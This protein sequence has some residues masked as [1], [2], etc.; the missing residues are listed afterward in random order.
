MLHQFF[1]SVI[2]GAGVGVHP[3]NIFQAVL[4]LSLCWFGGS[5]GG[6]VRAQ[7]IPESASVPAD[8]RA[9][10]PTPRF[11]DGVYLYGQSP[12]PE[13]LGQAYMVFEVRRENFVGA[14]YM[15]R[16]SFDCFTGRSRGNHLA[17]TIVDSYSQEP[18]AYSVNYDRASILA[19]RQGGADLQVGL[20]G[21]YPIEPVGENDRRILAVCKSDFDEI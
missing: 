8:D 5:L 6:S 16:S 10:T 11:R 12:E 14:F 2:S 20:E 15:P 21:F 1:H 13:Q 19:A 9:E 3:N 4:I 7:T 17:L 18:H